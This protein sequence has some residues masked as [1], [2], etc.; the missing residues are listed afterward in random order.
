MA[1]HDYVIA[2]GTGAAVRSDLNDAFAAIVS[3]NSGTTEPATTYAYQF[4]ADTSAGVLKLRNAA[5]NAWITLRELD[6]TLTMED[7][8]V[9]APGL[10]FASDLNTGIFTGGADQFNIATNGVERVEFG[11]S[12]VVFNDGG[13][14]YDFRIEG[15]TEA[16]LFFVDAS[17]DRVGLGTGSPA[18]KLHIEGTGQQTIRIRNSS[19]GSVASPQSS[20]IN[21]RGYYNTSLAQIEVQDRSASNFGGWI[22]ISTANSSNVLTNAIHIDSSQRVG[23]GTTSPQAKLSVSNSG[24][25]GIEFSP[26]YSSGLSSILAYNRTT[27]AHTE[28]GFEAT[29]F[30]F[31]ISG[32]E[33]ARL[34][35]SGRLLVGTSTA[36]TIY[37]GFVPSFQVETTSSAAAGIS[38]VS[39]ANT[40]AGVGLWMGHSRGSNGLLNDNDELGAILF[41]GGDGTDLE[42][43]GARITALIDGT[44]GS[45][46]LPSRLVFSTTLDGQSSPT[47]R[48]RITSSADTEIRIV[49][50]SATDTGGFAFVN[51]SQTRYWGIATNST[52]LYIHDDDFSNY[53]YLTQN[54]TAWQFASDK[55]LK[56]NIEDLDYGIDALKQIKARRFS[57]VG[58][59][60]TNIGFIAQELKEIIPE[61]VSGDEI[62]YEDTDT[63]QE[64]ASK[65]MGVGKDNLIPVLVK[66]LQEA[67]EKIE[68]LEAKVA[69]LEA[70]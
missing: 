64:K 45:N 56:E 46:D 14:N 30:P 16:N 37:P 55:R 57:F 59:T 67:I 29:Q 13:A 41:N 12:E 4:W 47:E 2:N 6:G 38:I 63:P 49:G 17:T 53:A 39:T 31:R 33:K 36:R 20:F 44:P 10:A 60:V 18:E 7:G 58:D 50:H 48:M 61:A 65:S 43:I 52:N 54:P 11:T 32:T 70:P 27:S 68:I 8:A 3:Q 15:D 34:D 5:N 1:Q 51:S 24:A 40:A 62:P 19:T 28:L 9:S 25:E 26:G 42:T 21:F 23:I 69:A 22:N 35:S 66:A